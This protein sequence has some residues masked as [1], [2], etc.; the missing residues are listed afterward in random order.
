VGRT[1]L[2]SAAAESSD[3]P[4]DR[5]TTTIRKTDLGFTSLRILTRSLS[6]RALRLQAGA[7]TIPASNLRF[8]IGRTLGWSRL[9]SDL[10]EITDAGDRFIF[11]GRG[12]GHGVGLCQA[13]AARMGEERKTYREILAFYYPGT[14]LGVTAQGLSW[15]TLGGER[16]QVITTRAQ[17]DK[18]TVALA[19]RLARIAEARSGLHWDA[20]PR[21]RIYPTVATFRD[22]TGEPG[23]VA[24]SAR[25]LTIRFQP[26]PPEPTI[27]HELLHALVESRANARLPLWFREGAVLYLTTS[28]KS[29]GKKVPP[30]ADSAFL[31]TQSEAR[32]AYHAAQTCFTALVDQFGEPTVLSWIGK[33]IPPAATQALTTK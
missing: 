31:H 5:W 6:G 27:L 33:G 8:S 2:P 4:H 7:T 21:L 12:S 32:Q 10:Y 28:Q 22:A 18:P 19:D 24:A 29:K 15:Q 30:P 11:E 1:V 25:G 3:P 20:T 17:Q 16:V 23:W 14:T 13:G 26:R 9:P